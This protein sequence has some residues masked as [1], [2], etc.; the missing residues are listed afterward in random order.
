[1]TESPAAA[2]RQETLTP[3]LER[4]VEMFA[5]PFGSG[6]DAAKG[7][8]DLLG[9]EDPTG[10]RLGQRL[11]LNRELSLSRRML[12]RRLLLRRPLPHRGTDA[13]ARRGGSEIGR[14]TKRR[15]GAAHQ[16]PHAGLMPPGQAA[17][18]FGT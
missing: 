14:A 6:A 3:A 9:E 16:R 13:S 5:T 2:E 17:A 10:P 12:R 11:M 4:A 15:A 7:Y 8:R 1:M 18:T